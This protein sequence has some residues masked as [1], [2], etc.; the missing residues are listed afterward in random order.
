MNYNAFLISASNA[1]KILDIINCISK[2]KL[3]LIQNSPTVNRINF[4]MLIGL[5]ESHSAVMT[6][7]SL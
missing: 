6:T 7:K 5:K 2:L 4:K 1:E 3:L